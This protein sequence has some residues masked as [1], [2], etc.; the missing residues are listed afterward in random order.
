MATAIAINSTIKQMLKH[1]RYHPRLNKGN[2][3]L[4]KLKGQKQTYETQNVLF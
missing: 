4:K 1:H 3:Q 2:H